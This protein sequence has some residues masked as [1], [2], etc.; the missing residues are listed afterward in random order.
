[1]TDEVAD[2][3]LR[4]NYEQAQAIST[5]V[6]Q[7]ASMVDVHARYIRH[8]EQKGRLDR[9]LEFLPD[10]ERLI[11]RKAAGE[12]LTA[13]EAAILLS[14]AKVTLYEE[15]LASDLP[16]D[17]D[18]V[19]ELERYFATPVRQRFRTRLE[20]HTLR[21]E[22]V[23]AQ[24][25]NALVNRAGTTFVFRLNEETGASGPEITRAFV[26]AREV[27]D[28]QSLW[29]EIEQ[30]DG[31]I[32]AQTQLAMLLKTR[33]LLERAT[34][35]FLRNRPRPL[36]IAATTA[37]FGPGAAALAEAASDVLCAADRNAARRAASELVGA[38]VP[39]ALADRVGHLESLLPVLDLVEVA[40]AT[41]LSL[42]DAT[43]V[44]FAIDDRLDL[45]S[46]RE[47][48]AALPRKE[49]WEALARRALWE[50][51]QSEHRALTADILR[52]STNGAVAER[53]ATWVTHNASAVERCEQVLADVKAGH[54]SDLATLS[55]AVRELRNLIDA[56][57]APASGV[58]E[59]VKRPVAPVGRTSG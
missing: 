31:R 21:R 30:L 24:V 7:A 28:L 48:I 42:D 45:H 38:G 19:G 27:F 55:V 18:L 8:L 58:N 20:R 1:M 13:P 57:A 16:D 17:P 56:T 29:K 26:V 51:L 14:Y 22:I 43:A 37:R 44:Y 50:D 54:A 49:R 41:G 5:S 12:G 32:A 59:P 40:A 25:T 3:V 34:R 15:V 39:R 35:W 23:A 2:L 6:S 33:V 52:E 4:D 47:R 36:D 9:A 46:L 11:E 10:D 53:V